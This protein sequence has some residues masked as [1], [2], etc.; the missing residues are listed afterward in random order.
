LFIVL[1][2]TGPRVSDLLAL[3]LDQYKLPGTLTFVPKSC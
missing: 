1:L 3:D 2:H